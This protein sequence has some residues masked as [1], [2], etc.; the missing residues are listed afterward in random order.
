MPDV[1]LG[2]VTRRVLD[3][4]TTI[5][6]VD[7]R[8]G[9]FTSHP[10][11]RS[12]LRKSLGLNVTS[13]APHVRRATTIPEDALRRHSFVFGPTGGGKSKCFE[14]LL[15]EQ[16]KQGASALI[17]D[18]KPQAIN[19]LIAI[20][21]DVGISPERITL[22]DPVR[23]QE[24]VP[25]L[26]PLLVRPLEPAV[27]DLA[28]LIES[29]VGG[30]APRLMDVL[31][32]ALLV[33]AAHRLSVLEVMRLLSDEPYRTELVAAAPLE[34]ETYAIAEA[35][36][37]FASEFT[38][39]TRQE[40]SGAT[41]PVLRRLRE[42]CRNSFLRPLLMAQE[43]TVEFASL[44]SE[45]RLILAHVEAS[46]LGDLGARL[47]AGLL[48]A[49]LYRSAM[50]TGGGPVPV[51]WVLDE[52]SLAERLVGRV[53][54]D[55]LA[56]AR[57]QNLRLMAA[58]QHLDQLS[59]S[60][61]ASLLTNA[62][63]RVCFRLG[64]ADARTVAG[65]LGATGDEPVLRLTVEVDRP[66]SDLDDP[67][68]GLPH[69]I[70]DA[71]GRPLRLNDTA[72]QILQRHPVRAQDPV[73]SLMLVCA[74]AGV[75]RLYVRD[76][77]SKRPVELRRYTAGLPPAE[78]TIAGPAPLQLVVTMPRPKVTGVERLREA[79]AVRAYRAALQ[80]L[81][82]RHALVTVFGNELGV[83]E[84]ADAPDPAPDPERA[85]FVERIYRAHGQSADAI[86]ATDV[87]RQTGIDAVRQGQRFIN[88]E[89]DDGSL[90]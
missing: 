50:R 37:F 1:V 87:A 64:P 77:D 24:W 31:V 56:V 2:H 29:S 69:R 8:L 18:P 51:V 75:P 44:W 49:M 82:V 60:L 11:F 7:R 15:R 66:R 4:Y 70:L 19:N 38:S 12:Y 89:N 3:T 86:R 33:C 58:C 25:G 42:L 65:Y 73:R 27:N 46:V 28:S 23:P 47:L 74:Q 21:K 43:N 30:S 79:D 48:S 9:I 53:I 10:G 59:P 76:P 14:V 17:E 90:R 68:V 39:W 52:L 6:C 84:I 54:E 67:R 61:R 34:P 80:Q 62:A 71:W 81:P 45:Q 32:N 83:V 20:A 5:Q 63:T 88:E 72:W 40:Q 57:S 16:L 35:R 22:L 78:L 55:T 13:P 36:R 26:N 85:S 41:A